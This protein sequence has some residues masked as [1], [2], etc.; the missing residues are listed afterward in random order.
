MILVTNSTWQFDAALPAGTNQF[1]FAANGAWLPDNWGDSS[2]TQTNL[3]L[4]GTAQSLGPNIT[5]N[6]VSNGVF[7]FT[8]NDQTLAYSLA[9]LAIV[10]PQLN[11]QMI[12]SN[13]TCALTFTNFPGTR[14]TVLTTT[15]LTLP[16]TNWTVLGATTE[17]APG[18][19]QFLDQTASNASVRYYRV[20][21]P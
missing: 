13:R 19:F 6:V 9:P 2:Q 17:A 21:S 15:N 14:F 12:F 8:F 5:A 16:L 7:R 10:P 3:P 4:T 11:G 18:Q 1:K 20:R